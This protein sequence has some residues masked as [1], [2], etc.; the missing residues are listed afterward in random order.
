[1]FRL[2]LIFLCFFQF[3]VISSY[4]AP[5]NL[6]H[7]SEK[8]S[9]RCLN[10]HF[11]IPSFFDEYPFL[12][13]QLGVNLQGSS[14]LWY[15][16]RISSQK[17]QAR[18]VLGGGGQFDLQVGIL[19]WLALFSNLSGGIVT[20]TGP[21]ILNIGIGG[22]F[23]YDV[24]ARFRLWQNDHYFLSSSVRLVG[25]GF[26]AFVPNDI[27]PT[28]P[29][30]LTSENFLICQNGPSR[31]GKSDKQIAFEQQ[32]ACHRLIV[33]LMR[34]DY[35]LGGKFDASFAIGINPAMGMW[36][37]GGYQHM[38]RSKTDLLNFWL[39]AFGE[40]AF[41][42]NLE[43]VISWPIGFTASA[44]YAYR[45][46]HINKN[47]FDVGAL[48]LKGG[49]YYSGRSNF[50]VGLEVADEIVPLGIGIADVRSNYFKA[51]LGVRYFWD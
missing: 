9:M 47:L 34:Y 41:S 46:D 1:M 5:L 33:E 27:I 10:G 32:N 35:E 25:T 23:E 38:F 22:Q 4:A 3:Y 28:A 43:P 13:T 17:V 30:I 45:L 42:F 36:V 37:T 18:Q 24:G 44:N 6:C 39:M 21:D 50:V 7:S 26:N 20:G 49:I 8:Q 16:N 2:F 31:D 14:G 11:F 51:N 29:N 48:T 19:N 12:T 40:I 15:D